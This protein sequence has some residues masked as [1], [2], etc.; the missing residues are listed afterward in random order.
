MEELERLLQPG[1]HVIID[2]IVF[3]LHGV[4]FINN[5]FHVLFSSQSGA[6][7][8]DMSITYGGRRIFE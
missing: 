2:G 3:T 6:P 1:P 5:K 4:E 8:G 7:S